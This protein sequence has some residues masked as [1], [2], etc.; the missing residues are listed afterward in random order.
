MRLTNA[1]KANLERQIIH[2][3]TD[4]HPQT[5][6][7][8][9]Y[10][11]CHL[12]CVGKTEG[13]YRR[14]Q[15]LVLNLRKQGDLPYKWISDGTRYRIKPATYD[16]IQAAL[17]ETAT[18]Y[19]RTLWRESDVYVEVWCESD[20][21]AGVLE[22]IT[23]RYDTSLMSSRGFSSH[24]FLHAAGVEITEI[25]KPTFI[26]YVG[27]WDA[28]GK[29]IGEKIAEQLRYFAPR[30]D[31]EFERILITPQQIDEFSLPSKPPKQN[32]H[33]R[34]FHSEC[35]VEAEAMPA[36]QTRQILEHAILRHIDPE[37]LKV[38]ETIEQEERNA[39]EIF[40]K[41]FASN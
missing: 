5:V 21:I 19:R 3:V 28:S 6:R 15:R 38:I 32:T 18:F 13:G 20:S 23:D 40:S 26:Y 34:G 2:V 39:L 37:K 41:A 8:V 10:Q 9:F 30:I 22:P 36:R 35:T 24:T 14:I 29:L 31:I 1:K 7:H 33:S 12:P 16:S 25:G 17:E 4:E 27:D 11:L